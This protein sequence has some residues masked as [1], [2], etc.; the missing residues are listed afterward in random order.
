M[1]ETV[2]CLL[3]EDIVELTDFTTSICSSVAYREFDALIPRRQ[4]AK[5][6]VTSRLAGGLWQYYSLN[7]RLGNQDADPKNTPLL[8]LN[9]Y[10]NWDYVTEM[11]CSDIAV[12][13]DAVNSYVATAWFPA[14]IQGYLTIEQGNKAEALTLATDNICMQ[15]AAIDS[16]F[17]RNLEGEKIGTVVV[18]TF[19]CIPSQI[20][21]QAII[22]GKPAAFGA[23][24]L[25]SSTDSEANIIATL[26][27]HKELYHHVSN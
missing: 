17:L 3:K 22:N 6:S 8:I 18:G 26:S 15:A 7:M 12:T 9:R 27:T 16:L 25:I 20:G 5:L 2:T 10:A 11:M 21:A 19:E 14:S 1:S 4:R 24:S 13:L 23:F